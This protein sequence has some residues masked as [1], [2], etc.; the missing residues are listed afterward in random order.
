MRQSGYFYLRD[1]IY[2]KEDKATGSYES[3]MRIEKNTMD[4]IFIK[5]CSM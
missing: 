1:I 4:F 2:L 5:F 3:K